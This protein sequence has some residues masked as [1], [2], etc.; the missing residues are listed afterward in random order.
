MDYFVILCVVF[1]T[2][3]S[4]VV[5]CWESFFIDRLLDCS[6]I[7]VYHVIS[8]Q[9]SSLGHLLISNCLDRSS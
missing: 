6:L 2:H 1:V 3:C 5:T 4:L 9:Q 8:E 7:I